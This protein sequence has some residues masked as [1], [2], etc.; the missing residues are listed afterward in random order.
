MAFAQLETPDGIDICYEIM[1]P[2]NDG[3]PIVLLHG[4]GLQMISWPDGFCK[5]LVD[6][7]HRVI[8]FDHRDS[9]E[10]S[11]LKYLPAP[12]AAFMALK[13]KLGMKITPPYNLEDMAGDL[14]GLLDG[15]GIEKAHLVGV[16]LGSMIA[17]VAAI[18]HASRL[19]SLTCIS[20]Q[21][22]NSRHAMPGIGTVLKIMRPPKPGRDGYINW[23]LNLVQVVGGAAAKAPDDYLRDIAG[24]MY[25]RGVNDS[26]MAR[27]VA[28][29]Y[30]SP[31]RR[32][33]LAKLS[34]PA[35][36]IHGAED[37]LISPQAS[38]EV[39][40]AIPGARFELIQ[41]MGHGILKPTWER[42]AELITEH[43]KGAESPPS[44]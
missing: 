20:T 5:M 38:K 3:I 34:L 8:R 12:S 35:L 37:P 1:G 10:S 32:P 19:A 21:A 15:L 26:G 30:A 41:G 13:H 31:D 25:D 17:Q 29:V 24:S 7:G 23:N 42:L 16:S 11:D 2:E 43:A 18:N 6:S 14:I 28:A 27:Q 4:A 9:G 40:D 36:V 44:R 39:A 33:A 22:R